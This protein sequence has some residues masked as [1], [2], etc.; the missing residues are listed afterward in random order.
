MGYFRRRRGGIGSK[1]CVNM[2]RIWGIRNREKFPGWNRGRNGGW[3]RGRRGGRR[4][5][6]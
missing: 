1:D 3:G 5:R 4:R 2:R 6:G